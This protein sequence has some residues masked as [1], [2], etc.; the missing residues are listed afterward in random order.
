MIDIELG[1]FKSSYWVK[2]NIVSLLSSTYLAYASH[3]G[4]YSFLTSNFQ[5]GITIGTTSVIRLAPLL[6]LPLTWLGNQVQDSLP[7]PPH[8]GSGSSWEMTELIQ[9]RDP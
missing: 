2:W 1:E 7:T 4:N 3:Y 9:I 5:N 6:G 8:A